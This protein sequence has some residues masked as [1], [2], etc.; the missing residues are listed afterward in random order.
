VKAIFFW[1]NLT[2]QPPSPFGEGGFDLKRS[3]TVPA[4]RGFD[5]KRSKI[6]LMESWGFDLKRSGKLVR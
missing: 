1:C 3:K 2:P 6:L 5:L 4:D